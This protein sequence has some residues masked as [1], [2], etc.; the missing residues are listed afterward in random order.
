MLNNLGNNGEALRVL[1]TESIIINAQ[2][3]IKDY[4]DSVQGYFSGKQV[5]KIHLKAIKETYTITPNSDVLGMYKLDG[6]FNFEPPLP[7]TLFNISSV[8]L[9]RN[10]EEIEFYGSTN[11]ESINFFPIGD[12]NLISGEKFV[13]GQPSNPSI[14]PVINDFRLQ[15]TLMGL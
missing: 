11:F 4:I 1:R 15:I 3:N 2:F 9:M 12:G 5:T 10:F 14:S 7:P 8:F 6:P 13:L